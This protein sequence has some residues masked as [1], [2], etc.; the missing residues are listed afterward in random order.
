M[1]GNSGGGKSSNNNHDPTLRDHEREKGV[2][3][4]A[5]NKEKMVDATPKRGSTRMKSP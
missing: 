1:R 4:M 3:G 5:I 2:S